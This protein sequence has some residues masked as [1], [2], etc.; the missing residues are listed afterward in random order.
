MQLSRHG[1]L[2]TDILLLRVGEDQGV[3]GLHPAALKSERTPGV[4]VVFNGID[5]QGIA[6]YLVSAYFGAAVH[7]PDAL[8]VLENVE[9]GNYHEY[10]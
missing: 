7:S 1:R 2:V 5:A 6:H 3:V 9:V 4:S 10:D 8:G